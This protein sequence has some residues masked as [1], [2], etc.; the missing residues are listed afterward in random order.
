MTD[1]EDGDRGIDDDANGEGSTAGDE[2]AD[3]ERSAA[4]ANEFPDH[5]GPPEVDGDHNPFA[6]LDDSRTVD[7]ED[8]TDREDITVHESTT[9]DEVG[10]NNELDPFAELDTS[11][12]PDAPPGSV[13]DPVERMAVDEV[14][15]DDVWDALEDDTDLPLA[16]EE[17]PG[18]DT[19]S[20]DVVDKRTYCH[21]CPHFAEPPTTACTLDGTDIVEVI[22]FDEFRLR[23]CP[24]VSESGPEFDRRQ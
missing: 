13:E 14:D 2:S 12:D 3:D 16:D 6:D 5:E 19:R 24:M 17:M 15:M 11:A 4:D 23:G 20:D 21:R 1:P 8:T 18:P 9:D 10:T 22:G 7:A